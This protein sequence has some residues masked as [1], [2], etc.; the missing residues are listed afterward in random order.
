M[1]GAC[2]SLYRNIT[3]ETSDWLKKDTWTPTSEKGG[4]RKEKGGEL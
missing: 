4:D 3:H 1:A 2:S